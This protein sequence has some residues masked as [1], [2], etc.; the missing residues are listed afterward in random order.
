MKKYFLL[1]LI[2]LIFQTNLNTQ[3]IQQS[4]SIIT[5]KKSIDQKNEI[6]TKK[7]NNK[8]NNESITLLFSHI[9]VLIVGIVLGLLARQTEFKK[10]LL[11]KRIEI[12][13]DFLE[14]SEVCRRDGITSIFRAHLDKENYDL[15]DLPNIIT[16]AYWPIILKKLSTKML[17]QDRYKT[18]FEKTINEIQSLT[19]DCHISD[20]KNLKIKDIEK[21]FLNIESIFEKSIN[22]TVS[23]FKL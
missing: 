11:Q 23:F 17:L 4:D 14:K 12:Y 8:N 19:I 13:S 3:T 7:D 21:S 10:Y 16:K 22:K 6:N 5:V 1:L 2:L 9:I 20:P 18:E 15:K